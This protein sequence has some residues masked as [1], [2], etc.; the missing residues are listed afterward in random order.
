[1]TEI[2]AE[3]VEAKL[4]QI[5]DIIAPWPQDARAIGHAVLF[6]AIRDAALELS[7][8]ILGDQDRRN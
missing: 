3:V 6:R 7:A 4:R 5:L 8:A 1:M 2:P